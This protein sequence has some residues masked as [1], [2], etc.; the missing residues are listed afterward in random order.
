LQHHL[1]PADLLQQLRFLGLT[2]FIVLGLHS[3]GEEFPGAIQQLPL[4]LADLDRISPRG[5]LP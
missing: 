5:V 2:V 1:Q 4:P 3:S